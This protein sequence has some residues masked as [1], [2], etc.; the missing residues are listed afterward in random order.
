MKCT[1]GIDHTSEFDQHGTNFCRSLLITLKRRIFQYRNFRHTLWIGS[2]NH[3]PRYPKD[4]LAIRTDYVEYKYDGFKIRLYSR[5]NL[6]QYLN[7][8]L[9]LTNQAG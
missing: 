6:I 5:V 8:K 4:I 9:N 1:Q 2:L 7:L 3:K